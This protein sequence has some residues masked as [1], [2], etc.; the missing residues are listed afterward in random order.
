M[1]YKR[2]RALQRESPPKE[3]SRRGLPGPYLPYLN[4]DDISHLPRCALSTSHISPIHDPDRLFQK[5]IGEPAGTDVG[6]ARGLRLRRRRGRARP[7][8]QLRRSRKEP[9]VKLRWPAP[10]KAV[11]RTSRTRSQRQAIRLR[12][13]PPPRSIAD[14]QDSVARKPTTANARGTRNRR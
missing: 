5:H 6:V 10:G 2:V 11:R 4:P 14:A 12:Q 1:F 8:R 9:A 3:Q 13:F 7:R